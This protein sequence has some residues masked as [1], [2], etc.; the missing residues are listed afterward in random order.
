MDSIESKLASLSKSK[1]RSS[2]SLK[3]KDVDYIKSKGLDVIESHAKGFI[4]KRLS[5]AVI[6]NDGHQTPMRGHPV[7]IAQHATA[8]CCRDCLY[9]WHKIEKNKDLSNLEFDYI[10]NIIMEWIKINLK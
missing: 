10:I 4:S 3:E 7:F 2:F 5:S 6:L 9:K 8:T 1:F